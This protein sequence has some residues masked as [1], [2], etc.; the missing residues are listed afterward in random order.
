MDLIP[1][2]DNRKAKKF[3]ELSPDQQ[4]YVLQYANLNILSR[5][6][7]KKIEAAG[8]D[9]EYYIDLWLR[10]QNTE[11]TRRAYADQLSVFRAFLDSI[12]V[13]LLL[14]QAEHTDRFKIQLESVKN[15]WGKPFSNNSIRQKL[16]CISSFYSILKRYNIVTDNPFFGIV[17]PKATQKTSST[18]GRDQS[19]VMTPEESKMILD[20]IKSKQDMPG[21]KIYEVRARQAARVYYCIFHF[22]RFY[23]LRLNEYHTIQFLNHNRFSVIGKGSKERQFEIKP[24]TRAIIEKY[25]LS[26]IPFADIKKNAIEKY[27]ERTIK[28]L[29][30][31]GLIQAEYTSHSFRHMRAREFYQESGNDLIATM[32]F[33]GHS[34]KGTTPIYLQ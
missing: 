14:C 30:A 10:Q 15:K 6:Q 19:P 17:R 18:P 4:E 28:N 29:I 33:L 27:L 21:N 9:L 34:I 3:E 11:N 31:A 2:N 20:Y 13:D 25:K 22:A 24:E 12:G 8:V 23:A 26:G 1:L 7:E 32:K 16:S 5:Q